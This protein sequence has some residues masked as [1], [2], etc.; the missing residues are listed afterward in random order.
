MPAHLCSHFYRRRNA[1]L[2]AEVRRDQRH[3]APSAG[4]HIWSESG[5][6]GGHCS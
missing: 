5:A 2:A 6:I 3:S 4:R 1:R